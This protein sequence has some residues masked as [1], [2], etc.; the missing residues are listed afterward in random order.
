MLGSK[1]FL[2]SLG[3]ATRLGDRSQQEP[4]PDETCAL[5]LSCTRDPFREQELA[6]IWD[7]EKHRVGGA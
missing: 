4:G 3:P 2:H 7:S 5:R 1:K 6:W